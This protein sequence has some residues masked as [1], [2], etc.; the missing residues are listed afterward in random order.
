MDVQED[1]IFPPHRPQKIEE[2]HSKPKKILSKPL[3]IPR[4]L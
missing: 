4:F 1:G 2:T 3:Q